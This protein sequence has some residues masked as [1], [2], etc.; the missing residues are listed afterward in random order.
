MESE[1]RKINRGI[2]L[3]WTAISAVLF[4]AYVAETVMGNRT[5]PYFTVFSLL[6]L[7]PL[8]VSWV[9]YRKNPENDKIKHLCSSFY[10]ILYVFVLLTGATPMVFVYVMPMIY[11][12]MLCNDEKLMLRIAFANVSINIVSIIVQ[13]TVDH[14]EP[15]LYMTEWEI[16]IAAALLCSIFCYTACRISTGLH[17]E[18]IRVTQE[19]EAKLQKVFEKVTEVAAAVENNTRQMRSQLVG[20][21]TAAGKTAGAMEEIVSGSSQS[22]Q[23]VERQLHMTSDIQA[24]IDHTNELTG[25]ISERV[26][27]T[28]ERVQT[29]IQD[30]RRLSES[31]KEVAENSREALEH[32]NLLRNMTVQVQDIVQIISGI[33]GQTNLLA[34]NA[35][36]EAARAGD[37]GRGFAVVAEEI[38]G[39]ANQTKESTQSIA[40][41]VGS[42]RDKAED[43]VRAVQRMA[44]LNE[45]QN[46]IIFDTEA[47][48]DTIRLAVEKVKCDTDEEKEQMERLLS[49]NAQIVESI[50]TISAVSEEVMANTAQTQEVTEENQRAVSEVTGLAQE[51]EEKVLELKSYT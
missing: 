44:E 49:A 28:S 48:F 17:T 36:I 51:L 15:E 16:Q 43:A 1:N 38:N 24:I 2:M 25:S 14:R 45:Q 12:L 18:R 41:M 19:G 7:V 26:D 50:Q 37:A 22:T 10:G 40:Q 5:V 35:S 21:E 34:L 3:G 11:L 9:Y 29:G 46:G 6:L 27:R 13:I 20:L 39:L 8:I 42:L 33:A 23:M 30:M 31:A 4:A 47:N 32:M